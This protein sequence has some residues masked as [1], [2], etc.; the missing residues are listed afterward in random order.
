[1]AE[2]EKT[3]APTESKKKGSNP[4]AWYKKKD[5]KAKIS[6]WVKVALWIIGI[7]FLVVFMLSRQIFG[8]DSI[9]GSLFGDSQNGFA[10]IS[11]WVTNHVRAFIQT[12]ILIVGT[13]MGYFVLKFLFSLFG[14]TGKSVGTVLSLIRSIIKYALIIM[15]I[16]MI[17]G[18][19]GVDTSTLV[20][21]LGILTLVI[22]L[23][24]QSLIN[25]IVSGLF[26]ISEKSFE[27]GDIVVIGDFRGTVQEVGIRSTKLLDAAGNI[28][29]VNNSAI[30]SCVNLSQELYVAVVD[31]IQVS[32]DVPL[33]KVEAIF[34][35][36]LKEVRTK[37]PAIVDGP[38]Y[39][40]VTGY[41]SDAGIG[42]KF[43]ARCR[44]EDRYQ[45]TRDM[46]REIYLL[47]NR[48]G[49][50]IPYSRL[51]VALVEQGGGDTATKKEQSKAQTFVDSEKEA[52]KG[53]EE[54]HK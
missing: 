33:E 2:E 47:M 39:K 31:T 34:A 30:T 37:V 45:V 4:F 28:K 16:F 12:A 51:N 21:S 9:L 11:L 19:W 44:E 6:F 1:M 5:R 23:G 8:A 27:V 10:S 52:S 42:L 7:A 38:F 49:L 22:G 15:D 46:N 13:L 32:Y 25:D 41:D 53:I 35:D 17:L 24:C 3:P 54:Q 48:Y 18:Y 20:T 29:I 43:I 40:G 36:H 26:L 14:K 50:D